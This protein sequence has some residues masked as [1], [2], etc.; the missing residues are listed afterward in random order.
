MVR[1]AF[2]TFLLTIFLV[3]WN[4]GCTVGCICLCFGT[5]LLTKMASV[6]LI[7][8]KTEFEPRSLKLPNHCTNYSQTPQLGIT[9]P[10]GKVRGRQ[11]HSCFRG[12]QGL[13]DTHHSP[14]GEPYANLCRTPNIWGTSKHTSSL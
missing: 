2:F 7:R 10:H 6:T 5:H 1:W 9:T 14:Y 3:V 11:Q 12:A 8:I 13:V 4:E